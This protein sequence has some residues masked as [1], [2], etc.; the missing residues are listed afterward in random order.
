MTTNIAVPA[1]GIRKV[2]L[3]QV[4]GIILNPHD[5][6]TDEIVIDS[7]HELRYTISGSTLTIHLV[8]AT[9]EDSQSSTPQ[10]IKFGGE[11]GSKFNVTISGNSPRTTVRFPRNSQARLETH[12][13]PESRQ[14]RWWQR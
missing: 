14:Q 4:P 9:T 1:A 7:P 2:K 13:F 5:G 3:A 12:N 10:T 6:E 11:D 8:A